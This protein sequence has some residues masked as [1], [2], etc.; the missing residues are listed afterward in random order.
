M[1]TINRYCITNLAMATTG[2]AVL[3]AYAQEKQVA[4]HLTKPNIIY[5][6]CDDLGYGQ[7]GC[8][9]QKMIQTPM[10]DRMAKEGLKFTDHYSGTAVCAPS[11]CS[12]MTG[13]H[14]GHAYIRGNMGLKNTPGQQ[15]I[16]TSET[17]VA[18]RLKEAGYATAAIGK[19]GL[20]PV[21]S[22]GDPNNQGFDLFY[23]FN[24]QK[25]AHHHFQSWLW[26]NDK[27]EE[28]DKKYNGKGYTHYHFTAEARKFIVDNKKKPFFLYLA[29]TIP[30]SKLEIPAED[31]CYKMYEN[32]KWPLA[33][34]KHAAMITRMDKDV[35]GILDLLKELKIDKNTLVVF[36]SDNGPHSEGGAK[37]AFFNRNGALRGIKRDMY[38]GGTRVP[39]ITWWPGTVTPGRSSDLVF[40]HWDLMATACEIGGV[41]LHDGTDSISYLPTLKGE[42][43]QQKKHKYVYFELHHPNRRAVRCGDWVAVQQYVSTESPDV[44]KIELFNLKKDL[45]QKNNVADKYPEKVSELKK[46]FV[47]AFTPSKLFPMDRD[48]KNGKKLQVNPV[49]NKK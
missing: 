5:I 26:R 23:G 7:V 14:I 45:E 15:P 48:F 49:K 41:K 10:I 34:K 12:L 29:Y 42:G 1:A 20:G 17:T 2:M 43:R 40:A 39:F 18:E 36:T 31:E 19:W 16:P 47:D 32:K 46:M 13:K 28:L 25:R 35:G 11:R 24:C 8:Y 37:P 4:S 30:H 3:G 9:G 27:K 21:G 38:E 6:M 22:E 33:Q 44:N